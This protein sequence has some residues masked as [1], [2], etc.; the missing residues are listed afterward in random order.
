MNYVKEPGLQIVFSLV[1]LILWTLEWFV[2]MDHFDFVPNEFVPSFGWG[3]FIA[4][5]LR[6]LCLALSWYTHTNLQKG[7]TLTIAD[8]RDEMDTGDVLLLGGMAPRQRQ[9]ESFN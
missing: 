4:L 2:D 1:V 6:T 9:G 3:I 8:L 7:I 5:F